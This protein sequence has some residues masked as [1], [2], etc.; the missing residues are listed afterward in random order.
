M[1]NMFDYQ[2]M[3]LIPKFC[4]VNS[5]SECDTSVKFGPRK[6]HLP[7]VPAN[8][9]CVINDDIAI[10]LAQYG[11]FYIHHRFDVDAVA[12]IRKMK[13]E[14]LFSSI[15]LGVSSEAYDMISYLNIQQLI[16]DY[17]T[18]DI[19]H[20]HSMQMKN[21]LTYIKQRLPSTFV[22]AG[23]VSTPEA[24]KDL[25][26]WGADCIKVGIGPGSACTTYNA[27]GFGSRGAQ[28]SI[29]EQCANAREF[30]ATRIIA[31]GG[32]T[33]HGDIAKSLVLGAHMVMIGGLFSSLT[34]SPGA[35]VNMDGQLFKEFWGSASSFQSNKKNRIEGTKKLLP[36]KPHSILDEMNTIKESLQ[37]AISYG[38]GATISCF[39]SVKYF[40]KHST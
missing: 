4:I 21:I 35:V 20:G 17:I 38:G 16:P 15:S 34:D 33:H 39:E 23:N 30:P 37:S 31:D 13:A 3:N 8:M 22:I 32:I 6:F 25:E 7:V 18:I 27:T 14:G 10:K 9:E 40:V 24:T 29:V 36:M 12:F 28:A 11:L 2:D 1:T 5:R 19:A 26:S